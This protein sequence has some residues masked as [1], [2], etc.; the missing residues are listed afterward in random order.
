[1]EENQPAAGLGRGGYT[2]VSALRRC[3]LLV[4]ITTK[5]NFREESEGGQRG[6]FVIACREL[7]PNVRTNVMKK[8]RYLFHNLAVDYGSL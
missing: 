8:R 4:N 1:M 5:V 6:S 3:Q 2:K 7:L